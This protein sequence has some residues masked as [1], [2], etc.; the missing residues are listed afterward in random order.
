[1][2]ELASS[3]FHGSLQEDFIMDT[4]ELRAAS[5]WLTKLHERFS[6]CFGRRESREHSLGYLRGLLLGAG[7]KSVEPMALVFGGS[8]PDQPEIEQ[9]VAL[10]WQRF[11]TQSPWEAKAVQQEI[12]AVFNEE[13]VP[14]ASQSP[15]GTVGVIDGSGFVKH[16]PESVGVQRQWCGRVG[17]KENCQV[18]VFLLGVTPAGNALLDHQLYL[19]ETWAADEAR[20]KKTRVPPEITFQTKPQIAATLVARSAVHFDWITADEEFGRDGDFL[21][22]LEGRNQRYMVEV[23]AN[24]TVWAD[25][26]LRQTPDQSVWQVSLLAQTIPAKAWRVIQLREGVK[27]PLAFEFARLRVWSVRHRHAGPQGWL[28]I[29]RSLEPVPEVK[30]Y[31]SNAE[32]DVPLETMALVTGSR[33]PVEEFFEDAK[34]KLGM[35]HYEARSWTSWHHHMSLV[36]LA[37]LYVMQVRRDLKPKT[38][39]LTLDMAMRLLQAAL[40]RPQLTLKDAGDLVD[41]YVDRN[42]QATKS[43]RKTW[44]AKH[45]NFVPRK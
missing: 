3:T 10:A 4:I 33:W 12:Q 38:P 16:G 24:T 17:K 1:L 28:V 34:G 6:P 7:R 27:G 18:G 30:Y 37:H 22:A 8:S 19:P 41:Y 14:S 44:L 35:A 36:A 29:R 43:H 11:L 13:F 32:S 25:K 39:E 2:I 21:D 40:P 15:I 23:P 31:L 5:E 42:K 45:P 20:R 26:P 9:S